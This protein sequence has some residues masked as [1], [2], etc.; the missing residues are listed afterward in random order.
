M[1]FFVNGRWL[2]FDSGGGGG[3]RLDVFSA[4]FR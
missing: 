4:S 2:I 1:I 3:G